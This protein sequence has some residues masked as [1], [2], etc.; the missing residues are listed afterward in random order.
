MAHQ[1]TTFDVVFDTEDPD[2]YQ[3]TA[4]YTSTD[5][6]HAP[7]WVFLYDENNELVA[8]ISS[9]RTLMIRRADSD[10]HRAPR[11]PSN[12]LSELARATEGIIV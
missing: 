7:G 5:E 1:N 4:A 9:F 10:P 12:P 2:T 3:V 11:K 8:R 6:E